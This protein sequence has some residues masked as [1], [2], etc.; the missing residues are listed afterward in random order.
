MERA[1]SPNE[2]IGA[3]LVPWSGYVVVPVFALAN[4]GVHL[5]TDLMARALTSPVTIG[6]FVALV[7]GKALGV[8]LT[9]T[10]AVRLR[11]GALPPGVD[12]RSV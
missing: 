1:I 6:V 8:G 4:A 7:A 2:R 9:A 5:S 10:A 3:L 12:L 11:L